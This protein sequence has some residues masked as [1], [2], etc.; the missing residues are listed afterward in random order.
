MVAGIDEGV[1]QIVDQLVAQD[2][3]E[4]TIIMFSID[5]GGVPYA[6]AFNY[7]LRGA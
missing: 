5:N 6:G 4:D 3:L 7:P 1:G 2:M